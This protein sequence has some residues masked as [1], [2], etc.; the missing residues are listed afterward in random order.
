MRLCHGSFSEETRERLKTAN[1][2]QDHVAL[3]SQPCE[4]CG[5][6]VVAENKT[7]EWVP[8]THETPPRHAYKSGK[9]GSH[10]RSGK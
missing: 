1:L 7:G 5:R 8:R 10:K 3:L 9:I 2:N 4:T 6:H